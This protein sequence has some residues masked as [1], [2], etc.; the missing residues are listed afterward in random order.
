MGGVSGRIG[1]LITRLA[2]PHEQ[3]ARE[4]FARLRAQ[5]PI[6]IE[7]MCRVRSLVCDGAGPLYALTAHRSEHPPGTLTVE[8]GEIL[9]TCDEHVVAAEPPEFVRS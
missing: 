4:S 6:P 1:E 3:R 8:A 7:A 9:R 5:G 2:R